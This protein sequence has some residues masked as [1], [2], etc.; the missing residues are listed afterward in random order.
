MKRG[1]F[2]PITYE[3]NPDGD[4]MDAE[5]VLLCDTINDLVGLETISS[6]CG[7]GY[8]PFRIYF[9]AD[10][11]EDLKPLLRVI[12][13]DENWRMRVD[14]ASNKEAEEVYFVLDGVQGDKGFDAA[15]RLATE[16]REQIIGVKAIVKAEGKS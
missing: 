7:H 9:V 8:A 16:L 4:K 10:T 12:D 5:C 6:C 3:T 11:P 13:E 14:R 15:I 1:N 2:A